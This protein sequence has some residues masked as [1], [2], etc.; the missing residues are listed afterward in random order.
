MDLPEIVRVMQLDALAVDVTVALRAHDVPHVILKGPSTSHWLYDPPRSYRD[1]DLLVPAGCLE[2]VVLVLESDGIA[3]ASA[4]RVGEEAPHSLL[5]VASTGFELDVH[6]LLPMM[7]PYRQASRDLWSA[8]EPHITTMPLGHDQIPVLD[9]PG[10]CVVLALHA[11]ASGYEDKQVA[12]DLRRA[13]G[14]APSGDWEA[15]A[16]LAEELGVLDLFVAGASMAEPERAAGTA[17]VEVLLKQAA[18]SGPAFGLQRLLEAPLRD[19]V[20][21][22]WREAFPTVGFMRRAYPGARGSHR[23]L[24]RAYA[25]RLAGIA[26]ELPQSVAAVARARRHSRRSRGEK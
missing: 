18:A 7:T 1:V 3:T 8:I 26:R 19:K 2:Q 5:M 4:G 14:C 22:M 13:R 9:H 15:A 24:A 20:R 25:V 17:S 16:Q 11:V 23:E 6:V 10:R 21:L 12:E